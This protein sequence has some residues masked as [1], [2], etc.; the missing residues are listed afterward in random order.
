MGNNLTINNID[1]SS[2]VLGN[3]EFKDDDLT[4]GGAATV[5]EG[6]ILARQA[7]DVAIVV[8]PDGGNVGTGTATASV[9]GVDELP[10]AG[11]YNLECTFEVAEG[12]VFKLV[13]PNGNIIADNLTLRV[14]AGLV[15]TFIVQG[16]EIA[17]T[18]GG[19]DFDIGDKFEIAV[20]AN[21]KLVPFAI[22]GVAGAGIPKTV[23][24]YDVTAAGAGDEAIRS[25]ISGEVRTEKLIIDADGDDSNITDAILDGL[26]DFGI[27][28]VSVEELNIQ[29]NQ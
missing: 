28:P 22:G 24:T 15:T 3:P 4:F 19:T 11:D 7:V 8:T 2:V 18:E 23:L 14:G 25:M 29:D 17:V 1:L 9:V 5:V 13:D 6:S 16:M 21:G 20:V 26:R 27:I 12:G 10:V